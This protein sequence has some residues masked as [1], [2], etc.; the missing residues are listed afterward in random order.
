MKLSILQKLISYIIITICG[1]TAFLTSIYVLFADRIKIQTHI[2]P[3]ILSLITILFILSLFLISFTLSKLI[4]EK[5]HQSLMRIILTLI[6]SFLGMNLLTVGQMLYSI[7]H[8]HDIIYYGKFFTINYIYTKEELF[9]YIP[10]LYQTMG[11]EVKV[12]LLKDQKLILGNA[13]TIRE[14][15]ENVANFIQLEQNPSFWTK[16]KKAAT[17]LFLEAIN[18]GISN[19][20]PAFGISTV[21]IA[22]IAFSIPSFRELY[23]SYNILKL[24]SNVDSLNQSVSTLGTDLTNINTI[25][26]V[27]NTSILEVSNNELNLRRILSGFIYFNSLSIEAF[28]LTETQKLNYKSYMIMFLD[29]L[30]GLEEAEELTDLIIAAKPTEFSL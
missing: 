8:F 15:Q 17:N 23:N 20:V 3:K 25:T 2:E 10:Y 27:M 28:N 1:Y 11:G 7:T 9:N 6:L 29:A 12:L 21:F 18:W 26:N 16:I 19:P 4:N 22:L 24:S 13:T 5:L 14:L 30:S